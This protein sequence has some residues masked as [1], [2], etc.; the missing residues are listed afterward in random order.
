MQTFS[1]VLLVFPLLSV[2]M[3]VYHEENKNQ[4]PGGKQNDD[5][6]FLSPYFF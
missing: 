4:Q 1:V 3:R 5:D 6:R 2:A